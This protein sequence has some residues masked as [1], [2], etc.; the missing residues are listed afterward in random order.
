[1]NYYDNENDNVLDGAQWEQLEMATHFMP[2]GQGFS[3]E[4]LF[5]GDW[6]QFTKEEKSIASFQYFER[7]AVGEAAILLS[8]G[9]NDHGLD[10]YTKP[11]NP[12]LM[13]V[14]LSLNSDVQ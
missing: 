11:F 10:M 12:F 8:L 5:Q 4:D 2:R 7:F 9:V 1:M 6:D 3:L 13:D 14:D